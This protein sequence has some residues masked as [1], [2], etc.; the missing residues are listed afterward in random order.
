MPGPLI[1]MI[2]TS[3]S[4][5]EDDIKPRVSNASLLTL[6]L[7]AVSGRFVELGEA[8]YTI[9]YPND[10]NQRFFDIT[11]YPELSALYS[12]NTS[13]EKSVNPLLANLSKTEIKDYL[14]T[15]I[16]FYTYYYK[17]G[18]ERYIYT[19]HFEHFKTNSTILP[20]VLAAPSADDDGSS[21]ITI[22]E[23]FYI[24]LYAK[25]GGLLSFVIHTLDAGKPESIGIIV[26]F[27][28]LN[29]TEFIKVVIDEY[30][31]I[32][33]IETKYSYTCSD[34]ALASKARYT[35]AFVIESAFKLSDNYIHLTEDLIKYLSFDYIL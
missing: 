14:I 4:L 32:L 25:E 12:R 30:Y 2:G 23:A 10:K 7:P 17:A 20:N 8:D 11:D 33:Y 19:E 3:K 9:L 15:F 34:H 28:D 18:A 1:K 16:S 31:D 24:L 5:G 21:T 22:L 29:L 35:S 27:I 13:K 6:L 26:D